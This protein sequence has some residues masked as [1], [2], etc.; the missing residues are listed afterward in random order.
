MRHIGKLSSILALGWILCCLPV[1]AQT[2]LAT[3]SPHQ[4]N[5]PKR[6]QA[7]LPDIQNPNPKIKLLSFRKLTEQDIKGQAKSDNIET[8][9]NEDFSLF[10]AGSEDA[11]DFTPIVS[12]YVLDENLTHEPGYTGGDIYQA[13]GVCL[14]GK[15]DYMWADTS[16][17]LS[18]STPES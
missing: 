12:D 4:E 17:P 13:G 10:T 14:L 2:R 3:A 15:E 9:L 5:M 16:I 11:P 8:I 1:S 6:I 18:K 7:D